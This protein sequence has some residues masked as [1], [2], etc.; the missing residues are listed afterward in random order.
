MTFPSPLFE[1]GFV[2][3]R[4]LFS[5]VIGYLALGNLLDLDQ[6]IGYAEHKGVPVAV[7]SVP[8]GSLGLIVGALAVLTGIYPGVGALVVIGCLVPITGLMH[9]FWTLEGEDRQTEQIHFFKNI[10]LIGTAV[11]FVTLSTV[12]WPLAVSITLW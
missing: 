10:G 11:A 2:L 9:D 4:L 7:V 12:P 8:L 6:S 5:V 3:S 1:A